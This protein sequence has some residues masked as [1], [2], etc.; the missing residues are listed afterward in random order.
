M[1]PSLSQPQVFFMGMDAPSDMPY[2]VLTGRVLVV[3]FLLVPL[4]HDANS[5]GLPA[6]DIIELAELASRVRQDYLHVHPCPSV[7]SRGCNCHV[8]VGTAELDLV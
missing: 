7:R 5:L 2:A 3:A 1:A 6:V 8:L 4:T